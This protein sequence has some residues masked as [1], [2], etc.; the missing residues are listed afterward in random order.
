LKVLFTPSGRDQFLAAIAYIYRDN[1]V[2]AVEFRHKAEKALARLGKFPQSGRILPEF[3]D[4][5]FREVIVTPYRF[6]Y[7]AKGRNVWVVAVWHGAQ[8]PGKPNEA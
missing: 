7:R 5:P 4:L 1:P 3:P 6:F 2:A 8:L